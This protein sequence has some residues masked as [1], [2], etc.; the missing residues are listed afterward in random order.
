MQQQPSQQQY[1][2]NFAENNLTNSIDVMESNV[3][4]LEKMPSPELVTPPKQPIDKK[5]MKM[6]GGTP[7]SNAVT[8]SA[9]NNTSFTPSLRRGEES[10]SDSSSCSDSCSHSSRSVSIDFR[11]HKNLPHRLL[12]GGG[13]RSPV[14]VTL[15][16]ACVK[17][18]ELQHPPLT[19]HERVLYWKIAD[20]FSDIEN[21]FDDA[22]YSMK[23]I[24]SER[25]SKNQLILFVM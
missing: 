8:S 2:G 7:P 3:K 19:T 23:P 11:F 10:S 13:G 16:E 6:M 18:N 4:M 9:S 20:E 15:T 22:M 24:R 21:D 17:L 14:R 5:A 25:V 12:A 1:L